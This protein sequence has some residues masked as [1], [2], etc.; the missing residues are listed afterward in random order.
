M[1]SGRRVAIAVALAVLLA[2]ALALALSGGADASAAAA[3][4]SRRLARLAT[5]TDHQL[6]AALAP[7]ADADAR[8]DQMRTYA[9]VGPPCLASPSSRLTPRV[10]AGGFACVRGRRPTG[11]T[12]RTSCVS[13]F[14]APR[15]TRCVRA[16]VLATGLPVRLTRSRTCGTLSRH[17]AMTVRQAVLADRARRAGLAH[18]GGGAHSCM[19]GP[20][21]SVA[22]S[23]AQHAQH[24][25]TGAP[26]GWR[27]RGPGHVPI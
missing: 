24:A 25:S 27:S 5:L 22:C 3:D 9:R 7:W 16:C 19:H 18:H 14:R 12:S 13:V 17:A 15:A 21:G 23:D 4:S 20:P 11:T 6:D 8:W 2:L 26:W 10:H 1:A